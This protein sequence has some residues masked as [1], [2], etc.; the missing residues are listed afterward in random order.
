MTNVAAGRINADSTDAVNGSQLYATN[1]KV[2]ENTQDIAN[3]NQQVGSNTQSINNL[4]NRIDGVQRDANAGT[5]SAMALA[6]LPQAV[7]PGKGMVALAGSTY[8]GQSALALGVSALS[9]SGK[10]VFKGGVTTNSRGN[11]GATVGAGFHW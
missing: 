3:L 6:G 9:D 7:L 1:Q 8:S 11:V 5:A 2:D 10:W 4:N